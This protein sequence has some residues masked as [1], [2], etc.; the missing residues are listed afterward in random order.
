MPKL[1][2]VTRAGRDSIGH[3][4]I[5]VCAQTRMPLRTLLFPKKDSAFVLTLRFLLGSFLVSSFA[6]GQQNSTHP[7]PDL[8]RGAPSPAELVALRIL[9]SSTGLLGLWSSDLGE[10]NSEPQAPRN[11]GEKIDSA[12]AQQGGSF[13]FYVLFFS[14]FL[15]G[16][17]GGGT[18]KMAKRRKATLSW[19]L[20]CPASFADLT[21]QAKRR[22]CRWLCHLCTGPHP[23]TACAVSDGSGAALL[24]K[25]K[26]KS[27]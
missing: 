19:V 21:P 10:K 25:P 26:K 18:R 12:G 5:Q 11:P 16:G 9:C 22:A 13:S 8:P 20:R 7:P 17:G 15:F 14:L 27:D 24:L 4:H 2:Q 23:E 1:G 6:A 3:A